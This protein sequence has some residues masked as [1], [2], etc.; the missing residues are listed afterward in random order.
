MNI[1][2]QMYMEELQ[3]K[4]M[5]SREMLDKDCAQTVT[6]ARPIRIAL[7]EMDARLSYLQVKI[8]RPLSALS[9]VTTISPTNN[10]P[11]EQGN[12]VAARE[13]NSPLNV[14]IKAMADRLGAITAVLELQ[15]DRLEL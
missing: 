4:N 1:L 13:G 8:D 12:P 14:E 2:F 15:V 5:N 3:K 10:P 9:P 11:D 6:G 7:N